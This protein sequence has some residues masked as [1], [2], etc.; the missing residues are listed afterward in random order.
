[1]SEVVWVAGVERQVVRER[2]GGNQYVDGSASARVAAS[3]DDGNVDASISACG[4][5]V[6]G[7]RVKRGLR[8]L[9]SILT[10]GAFDWVVSGVRT[11]RQFGHREGG[12]RDALRQP[13][14]IDRSKVD[15][16]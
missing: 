7:Q 5:G 11:C 1:V 4:V 10:A 16:N 14:G 12:H 2:G 8:S 3:R 13:L 9:Q 15:D 6:E